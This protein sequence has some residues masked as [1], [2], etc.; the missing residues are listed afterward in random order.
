MVC[1]LKPDEKLNVTT[2]WIL[3]VQVCLCQGGTQN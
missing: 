2:A 1:P 3:T